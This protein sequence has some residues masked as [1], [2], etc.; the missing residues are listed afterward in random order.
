MVKMSVAAKP[1]TDSGS[2]LGIPLKKGIHISK[3]LKYRL[4]SAT[5]YHFHCKKSLPSLRNADIP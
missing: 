3:E 5:D 2:S 1:L 4:L